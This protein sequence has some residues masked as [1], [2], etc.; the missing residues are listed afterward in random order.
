VAD[1]QA[2]RA[3]VDQL[4]AYHAPISRALTDE[5]TALESR[6]I[7]VSA[8]IITSC[9]EAFLRYPDL[10]AAIDAARP[11]EEIGR[12]ARRPGCRV[13]TVSL[14]SIAN[15]WLLGRKVM[16]M[17]DPGATD[18]VD[19]AHT[20]LDFWERAAAGFRGDGTRQAWD[21]GTVAVYDE[22][23]VEQLQAGVTQ[24]GDDDRLRITR[25]NATLIAYLFLLYFDTRVGAGDTGPYPLPDGRVLLVRD[26]YQLADSDFW[27]SGVAAAVPYRNL[28]AALVLDGVQVDRITDFGTTYTT[29]EDYLDHLVGFGL[30]TTDGQPPGVLAPVPRSE[31]EAIVAAVRPAQS[32]LYRAVAAMDRHE[33]IRCGAYV[34]FSFLR[35]YA[36]EAG[37]ADELDWTVPRDIPGPLYELVSAMEGDNAGVAD[38]GPYYAPLA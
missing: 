9:I 16:A 10:M 6:L 12:R 25:F 5:R 19:A 4:I 14:W 2:R 38:D 35:P 17:V 20:V 18:D 34:Y 23:I 24:V 36:A 26:Y 27:W 22:A 15:F 3:R 33:K 11:A 32:A 30:F 21:T 31:L 7:P 28:T 1:V 13:N 37:L 29:P 8:Y